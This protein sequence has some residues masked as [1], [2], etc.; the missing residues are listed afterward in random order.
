MMAPGSGTAAIPAPPPWAGPP[1]EDTTAK[2][3]ATTFTSPRVDGTLTTAS[4]S[5]WKSE[6]LTVPANTRTVAL[7]PAQNEPPSRMS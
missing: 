6:A 1:A 2:T 3:E 4:P 5:L 7:P